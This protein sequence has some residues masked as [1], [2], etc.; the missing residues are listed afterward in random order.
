MVKFW[1]FRVEG[2]SQ[3][4]KDSSISS[5]LIG[6]DICD[7]RTRRVLVL[8]LLQIADSCLFGDFTELGILARD[9]FLR[10]QQG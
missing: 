8:K 7:H 3:F 10:P 2:A 9:Y 1:G 6:S 4:F 5:Y